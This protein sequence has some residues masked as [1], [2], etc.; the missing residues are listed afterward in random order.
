MLPKHDKTT[1][2]HF[3]AAGHPTALY[4]H[5]ILNPLRTLQEF[6]GVQ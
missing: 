2:A 3:V 6:Y 5:L 1:N 4:S